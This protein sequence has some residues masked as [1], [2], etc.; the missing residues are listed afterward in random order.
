METIEQIDEVQTAP[1]GSLDLAICPEEIRMLDPNADILWAKF[2][3]RTGIP[4]SAK[5][6]KGKCGKRR[7]G[8]QQL[9]TCSN[10]PQFRYPIPTATP[11]G[12]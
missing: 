2:L 10:H 12:M 4:M 5:A 6:K 1:A 9:P 8:G 11:S 3:R 7:V